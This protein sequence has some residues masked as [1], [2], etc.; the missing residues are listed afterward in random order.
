MRS[1]VFFA[2]GQ[3]HSLFNPAPAGGTAYLYVRQS[4][5]RQVF[6]N[7]A[8]VATLDLQVVLGTCSRSWRGFA[9]AALSNIPDGRDDRGSANRWKKS[10]RAWN[11]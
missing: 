6:E 3:T 10:I 5:L 2:A 4:T 7:G 9:A 1:S 11:T 8:R